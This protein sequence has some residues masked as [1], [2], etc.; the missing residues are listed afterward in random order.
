MSI[1]NRTGS[2]RRVLMAG[3]VVA[4]GAFAVGVATPSAAQAQS[5]SYQYNNPAYG[6]YPYNDAYRHYAWWRWHQYWRAYHQY[7]GR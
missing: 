2:I 7:Y 5:Y 6:S 1:V 4:S 3:I